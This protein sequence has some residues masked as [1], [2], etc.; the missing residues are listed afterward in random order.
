MVET[1]PKFFMCYSREDSD[2]VRGLATKLRTSGASVWIDQLDILGGQSWDSAVEEALNACAG[3]IVALSPHSVNSAHVRSEL[4]FA[5]ESGKLIVPIVIRTCK[6]PLIIQ[7]LQ[8]ID[9]CASFDQGFQQL[10]RSLNL[11]RHDKTK[12]PTHIR[13]TAPAPSPNQDGETPTLKDEEI[14]RLFKL[15]NLARAKDREFFDFLAPIVTNLAD[16]LE[17]VVQGNLVI[18]GNEE[19]TRY[20][21]NAFKQA[22]GNVA[23][24]DIDTDLKKLDHWRQPTVEN[25]LEHNKAVVEAGFEFTRIFVFH[26]TDVVDD[27]G[28]LRGPVFDVLDK[29]KECDVQVMIAWNDDLINLR[30]PIVLQEEY[31]LFLGDK[32]LL[33][34]VPHGLPYYETVSV[35]R[36]IDPVVERHNRIMDVAFP[37]QS[38]TQRK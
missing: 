37:L 11:E 38:V 20:I 35:T 23:A 9:F 24:L 8:R 18:K 17:G 4:L 27:D 26:Q 10:L 29:H 14:S 3:L 13:D 31:V 33:A 32:A 28:M 25:Y 30:P 12:G 19:R 15:I 7:R 16:M 1:R 22:K 21:L 36:H 6:T 2:F 34:G 5:E